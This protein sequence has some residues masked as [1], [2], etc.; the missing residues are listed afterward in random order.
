MTRGS[1]N[2]CGTA[3]T[4]RRYFPQDLVYKR[5]HESG[6]YDY[7]SNGPLL[8]VAVVW[9]DKRYI[10]FVSTLYRNETSGD[11][12]TVKRCQLGGCWMSTTLTR[13]PSVHAGCW[14]LCTPDNDHYRAYSRSRQGLGHD[15]SHK[16]RRGLT[17]IGVVK[18]SYIGERACLPM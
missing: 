14:S 4:N 15:R 3:W 11:P 10:Y 5:N 18:S 6:F 12:T 8:A 9:M 17:K 1:I 2:A 13:L 16:C 7:T